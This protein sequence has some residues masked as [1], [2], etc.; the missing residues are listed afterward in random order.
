MGERVRVRG[1][2]LF[3]NFRIKCAPSPP[4]L[5]PDKVEGEGAQPSED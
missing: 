3:R 1:L 4:T 5:S 2:L